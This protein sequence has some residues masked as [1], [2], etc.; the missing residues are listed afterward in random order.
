[1][2]CYS[3]RLNISL[4]EYIHFLFCASLQLEHSPLYKRKNNHLIENLCTN[5]V[6]HYLNY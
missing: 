3:K 6:I 4:G 5:N 2:F 1:M